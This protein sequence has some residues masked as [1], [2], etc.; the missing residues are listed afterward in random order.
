M[1]G[2]KAVDY[3]V[4]LRQAMAAGADRETVQ[5]LLERRVEKILGDPGLYQYLNDDIYKNTIQYLSTASSSQV[6]PE[7]GYLEA[8]KK[9]ALEA[10]ES[11]T[12]AAVEALGEQEPLIRASAA[13][14]RAR[15]YAAARLSALGN[16]ERMATLG[17]GAGAQNAPVSGYQ[18]TSRLQQDLA[19][20]NSVNQV[21]SLEASALRD[22]AG[23][24]REAR[25]TGMADV[26]GLEEKY[27]LLYAQWQQQE[28][29]DQYARQ[30]DFEQGLYAKQQD[31]QTAYNQQLQQA[32]RE[33]QNRYDQAFQRWKATGV[34]SAED[35]AVLGVPAGTKT[36]DYQAQL[37]A[38]NRAASS[39]AGAKK[40]GGKKTTSSSSSGAGQPAWLKQAQSVYVKK[41]R[42][43]AVDYLVAYGLRGA[44]LAAALKKLGMDQS[45][46]DSTVKAHAAVT[47]PKKIVTGSVSVSSK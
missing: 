35:A 38:M 23:Q 15:A 3:G 47:A 16:E 11:Q 29:A 10:R 12:R 44:D 43:A 20:E 19:L 45:Y 39:G 21:N 26:S 41:G 42:D 7:L 24:I 1:S 46:I 18:E 33:Q 8:A 5:G 9:A 34:V 6:S 32:Y 27:A 4:L 17:L 28:R 31:A 13:E 37:A 30:Q 14:N 22:L 25:L 40:S 2:G 36:A